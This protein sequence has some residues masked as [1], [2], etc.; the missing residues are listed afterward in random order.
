MKSSRLQPLKMAL[1]GF[2]KSRGYLN[3]C[4]ELEV[5]RM[6]PEIAGERLSR[7]TEC[8][9]VDDGR[10]FIRVPSS[11]WRHEIS[12]LKQQLLQKIRTHTK[13]TSI[14]NIVFY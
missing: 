12:Y 10:L 4:R 13:C 6:W 9:G 7:V 2:L 14:K 8:T 11:T 3:V 1:E 5:A